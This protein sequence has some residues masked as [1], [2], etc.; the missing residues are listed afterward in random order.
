MSRFYG[1]LCSHILHC[2][3]D[4]MVCYGCCQ[5]VYVVGLQRCACSWT[6]VW[7]YTEVHGL[8]HRRFVITRCCRGNQPH[9]ADVLCVH[10]MYGYPFICF[11]S[12]DRLSL[13][14]HSGRVFSR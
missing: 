1:S 10:F 2:E 13:Y 14:G 9:Q 5:N 3:K 7:C 11:P 12:D 4:V 8:L 6:S